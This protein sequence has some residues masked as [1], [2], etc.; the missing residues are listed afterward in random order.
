MGSWS[1]CSDSQR[2]LVQVGC[3]T[4]LL[5]PEER[6]WPGLCH[7]LASL[8]L[9]DTRPSVTCPSLCPSSSHYAG[10]RLSQV[11]SRKMV[12]GAG[13][14]GSPPQRL[15]DPCSKQRAHCQALWGPEEDT[16]LQL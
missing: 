1:P 14:R 6:A 9:L 7:L 15:L 12:R 2:C 4:L 16:P 13:P 8:I 3:F 10:S 11:A 5:L